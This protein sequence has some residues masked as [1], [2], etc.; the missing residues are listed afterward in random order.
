MSNEVVNF[1]NTLVGAGLA[2]LVGTVILGL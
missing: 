1:I 2:F